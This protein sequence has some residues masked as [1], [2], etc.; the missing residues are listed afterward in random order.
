MTRPITRITPGVAGLAVTE[1][2]YH[3]VGVESR[4]R[5][6]GVALGTV[7]A[8]CIIV[9]AAAVADAAAWLGGDR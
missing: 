4:A 1:G 3:N 6:V 2:I 5:V 8:V 9:P 7:A